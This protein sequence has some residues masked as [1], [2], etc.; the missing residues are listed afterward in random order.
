LGV[1]G[2]AYA[3]AAIQEVLNHP[4]PNGSEIRLVSI[5]RT[6]DT[7]VPAVELFI[8]TRTGDAL[9]RMFVAA[10]KQLEAL[11]VDLGHYVA[12]C[13]WSAE[14]RIGDIAEGLMGIAE[15]WEADLIVVGSHGRTGIS[16]LLLGSVSEAL[17]TNAPCPVLVVKRKNADDA[18]ETQ[19]DYKR[20]LVPLDD[21]YFSGV[22]M[23]W[24][25]GRMWPPDAQ[26]CL[27]HV[28]NHDLRETKEEIHARHADHET[29]AQ[30]KSAIHEAG[31]I[32]LKARADYLG[33]KMGH[34]RFTCKV[35]D[36]KPSHAIV[37][38]AEKWKADLIVMGSHGHTS[39]GLLKLGS[40]T[41]EVTSKAACSVEVV[42][43]PHSLLPGH[44]GH[45]EHE[46]VDQHV[47]IME[48][49]PA[50]S[51]SRPHVPPGGL[52]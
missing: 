11:A 10:K 52:Y 38:M 24:I 4:W 12:N 48:D 22:A 47:Q 45:Q 9:G 2:S 29:A 44:A 17:V 7:Y 6:L 31:M 41:A 43:V 34:H 42:R 35:E 13:K 14:V 30:H 39:K 8:D 16:K 40:T 1:D 49:S 5:I 32:A 26:F 25:A 3:K 19:T 21:S 33:E 36:G 50:Q 37:E 46:H 28:A 18:S 51:D 23:H 27:L 15:E 20:I